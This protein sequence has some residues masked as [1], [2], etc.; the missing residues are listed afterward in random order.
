MLALNSLVHMH[1]GGAFF[2]RIS[3]EASKNMKGSEI[4]YLK[5]GKPSRPSR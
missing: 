1:V 4:E 5:Q 2:R 3:L